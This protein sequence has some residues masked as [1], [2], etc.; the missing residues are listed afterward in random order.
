MAPIDTLEPERC[1]KMLAALAA[2]ERL[3][4]VRHLAGGPRCVSD[5]AAMLGVPAVNASH[6]LQVLQAAGLVEG[7]RRGRF[8]DYAIAPGMLRRLEQ[9]GG[10]GSGSLDLGCCQFVIPVERLRA[11]STRRSA[12]GGQPSPH[13][14]SRP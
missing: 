14:A 3:R 4:I 5:I 6:H 7:K 10:A 13:R 9:S 11:S 12:R 8:I 2:P 1:A